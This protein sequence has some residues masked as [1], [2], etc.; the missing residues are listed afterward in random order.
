MSLRDFGASAPEKRKGRAGARLLAAEPGLALRGV[1]HRA[2]AGRGVGVLGEVA[3]LDVVALPDRAGGGLGATGQGLDQ[4]RLAGAVGADEHDVLAPLDFELGSREKRPPGDLDRRPDQFEDNPPG[5]LRGLEGEAQVAA[6]P[7]FGARPLALDLVDL[8]EARLR[9]LRLGR[10]VAE[11]LDEA[12]HPLDLRLLA[13]D[14]LAE[15]DLPR[16]LLLAPGVP[17]PGEEAGALRLQLEDGGADR[18][19]EP[20]VV[21]DED[22]GRV[23]VAEVSLQPLQRRYVEVVGRL[24][25]QQQVRP[26]GEGAGQRRAGQLA[27]GEG[28]E[29]PVGVGLLEAES[30]EDG[31]DAVAPAIAAAVVEELLGGRVCAHRLLAGTTGR[32]LLLKPGQLG[33]GLEHLGA[34]GEDVLAQRGPGFARRALVVQGDAGALLQDEAARVGRQLSGEHPQQRRLAGAV[35]PREGHPL[36]RLELEGDVGEEQLAA[37]VHVQGCRGH[38]RHGQPGRI[39]S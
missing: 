10:L 38:D 14:R 29:P 21:S 22:D 12:L 11:A 6:V 1:E 19:Q 20:A 5:P 26:R 8:L 24:V 27:A 28:R 39:G 2:L 17:G 23:E 15:G 13:L 7:L 33:L 25:E 3:D 36:A 9:L 37:E 34:A 35:A 30:G 31:E 4:G 18:L 16:G 32:H